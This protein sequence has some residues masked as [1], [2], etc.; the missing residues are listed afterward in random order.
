MEHGKVEQEGCTQ[1]AKLRHLAR[2]QRNYSHVHGVEVLPQTAGGSNF[3]IIRGYAV[4]VGCPMPGSW[5]FFDYL[6]PAMVFGR[7]ADMSWEASEHELFEAARELRETPGTGDAQVTLHVLLATDPRRDVDEADVL[8][9]WIE[10]VDHRT[11]HYYPRAQ[12]RK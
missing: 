9:R 12:D 6:E 10:N 4:L 8:Q 7:A 11:A 1:C 2:P 3:R 5:F